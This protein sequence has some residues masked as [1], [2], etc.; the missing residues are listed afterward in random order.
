MLG[1]VSFSVPEGS[2]TAIV[3]P[4][5]SGKSTI[6][7]LLARFWVV[8]NSELTLGGVSIKKMPVSQLMDSISYVSQENFLLD[9][10]IRENIRIGYP[11]ASDKEIEAAAEKAGCGEFIGRLHMARIPV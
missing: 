10:T 3:G 6:A 1:G 4:S 9:M 11:N 2:V 5:G 7:R 8:D